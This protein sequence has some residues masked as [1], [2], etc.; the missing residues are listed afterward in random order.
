MPAPADTLT[1]DWVDG[2]VRLIDQRR[3]PEEFVLLDLR[4]YGDL[5]E[6]IRSMAVRGAPALGVAGALGVALA[7]AQMAGEREQVFWEGLA[8]AADH[9]RGTRPT[10]VNL[11]GGIERAFRAA[12]AH[13]A[14]GPA[15]A[16]A[17][18]LAEARTMI[19]EDIAANREM[20]R[21]GA[22]LL[23]DQGNVLTHCNTG[24]LATVHYG[25]ALGVVR[26]AVEMGHR[27][28]VWVSETRPRLQGAKLTAWECQQLG[29]SHTLIADNVA[30][31][32]MRQGRVDAVIVGADRVA[33]NGD[34]ANKIGTYS[35][36]V[37]ARAHRVP[38]YVAAPVSTI[39]RQ[40][41]SGEAIP[42]EERS[43]EEV[44][45]VSG[46]R[47]TPP[48]VVAYNPAFDVTP[49]RLISAL[50]TERGVARPPTTESLQ[51]LF[52]TPATAGPCL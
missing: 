30:G 3:L 25:T 15:G 34:T 27:L 47:I 2:G 7:A 44:T 51:E 38:F 16:A 6:A 21:H 29:I 10:A 20:G 50:I 22:A 42:I 32:L 11:F 45:T 1:I 23:P 5:A 39:D 40:L 17:A 48:G 43:A 37:L 35:L 12:A 49:A 28:H 41:A 19:E 4:D 33:A 24:S 18:A 52:P 31:W 9:L 46:R 26:A 13:R 14:E 8:Q 36:A